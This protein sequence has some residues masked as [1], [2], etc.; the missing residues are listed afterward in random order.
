MF[1]HTG[2]EFLLTKQDG[3]HYVFE[4][5]KNTEWTCIAFHPEQPHSCKEVLS[6]KRIVLKT[7]LCF[8]PHTIKQV[9]REHEPMGIVDNIGFFS[10]E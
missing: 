1:A 8:T 5:S 3:S 7:E 10:I 6:G 9:K 4:S 2:G